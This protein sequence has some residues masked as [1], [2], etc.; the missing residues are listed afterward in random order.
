MRSIFQQ[1]FPKKN[2]DACIAAAVG[3]FII[4]MYTR[5]SGVG[6]SPDSVVYM[7]AAR[8]VHTHAVLNDFYDRPL[9]VFP[10][11]YPFFLSAVITVTTLDPMVFAPVLNALLFAIIIY[12]S[13]WIMEN[14]QVRSKWYKHII[15]SCIALSPCL[16]EIYS[17]MW[18]ETLFILLLL[19][20]IIALRHYFKFYSFKSLGLV[21]FV[22]A[23]ACITRYAGVTMIAAGGLLILLDNKIIFKKKIIPAF[24]F[25]LMSSSLLAINLIRNTFSDGTF[26]GMREKSLASLA[27]NIYYYGNVLC[28]WLPLPKD[29]FI[30]VFCTAI[31]FLA[32]FALLIWRN[33]KN[34]SLNSFE[35]INVVFFLV[36]SLFIIF[37]ATFSRYELIN[38]RLLSPLFVTMLLGG[39]A[40]LLAPA[41]KFWAKQRL[42]VIVIPA[43]LVFAFQRHQYKA[44]YENYD[45]IKDAG[46]PGYT[47]DTWQEDS[48]IVNFLK[49]NTQLFKKGYA[50]YSNSDDALYFLT[51][52]RCDMLPHKVFADEINNYYIE[53][54]CYLVWFDDIDNPELLSLQDVL[55]HKKMDLLYKFSNG[56]I[57]L[58][59]P[60]K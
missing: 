8:N 26:T 44:D 33:Y 7:S 52:L 43:L 3:F 39:T 54:N 38:S 36:Y 59:A 10:A 18:S 1:L 23:L 27:D 4:Y 35:N 53:N 49:K 46:I 28:E 58:T 16:L 45:G 37:S 9:V 57:Y 14:F 2:Y 6:V 11:F 47:E 15:L 34:G 40:W 20:F 30:P 32:G 51:G 56:A 24:L 22:A 12:T 13:G 60:V 55:S 31:I 29:R 21:S 25:G 5:H 42:L 48:E 50:I 17:M 41:K 19:F